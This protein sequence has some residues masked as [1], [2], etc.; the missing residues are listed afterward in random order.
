[1]STERCSVRRYE[2]KENES[3]M[4]PKVQRAAST[5]TG[6]AAYLFKDELERSRGPQRGDEPNP[7]G[8]AWGNEIANIAG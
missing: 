6:T 8:L 1:M 7:L 2:E 4:K 5:S 3:R